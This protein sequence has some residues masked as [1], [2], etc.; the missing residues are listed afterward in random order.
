MPKDKFF[1]IKWIMNKAR[2]LIIL[3]R[4]LETEISFAKNQHTSAK[5][6]KDQKFRSDFR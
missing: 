3:E 2:T 5:R 6:V 4:S 1:G